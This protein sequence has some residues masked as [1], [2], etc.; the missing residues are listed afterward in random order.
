[1]SEKSPL[2]R[3]PEEPNA[4]SWEGGCLWS[5]VGVILGGVALG[6]VFVLVSLTRVSR[7]EQA[8]DPEVTIIAPVTITPRPEPTTSDPEENVVEMTATAAFGVSEV[9]SEGDLVEVYGTEGQGLSLRQ[10][11]GISSPIGEYGLESEVFEVFGGPVDADG[12][13][14]WYLVNPYDDTKQGWGVGRYLRKIS[15]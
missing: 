14:W 4:R 6:L 1:M 9:F 5:G 15:P 8:S 2:M 11:P 3:E 13:T 12:Y 10:A 7:I